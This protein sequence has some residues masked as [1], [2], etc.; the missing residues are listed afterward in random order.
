MENPLV[1][2]SPI[3]SVDLGLN[4]IDD[5]SQPGF[6]LSD[7]S[8]LKSA[9]SGSENSLDKAFN[10]SNGDTEKAL[11][12]VTF[13]IQ[14]L[15]DTEFTYINAL[16]DVVDGYIC[17]LRADPTSGFDETT[18]LEAFINIEEILS[19]HRV[20]HSELLASDSNPHRVAELFLSNIPT[21]TRLYVEFCAAFPASLSRL[22]QLHNSE[23]SKSALAQCQ[24]ELG[25]IFPVEEYLHRA[26]QRF[27][28]YPLLFK[29]MNKKLSPIVGY[30]IVKEALDQLLITALKINSV[31]RVQELEAVELI[32]WKGEKLTNMGDLLLE[33]SFKISGAK[34]PRYLFLFKKCLLVTK[35]KENSDTTCSFAYKSFFSLD[36]ITLKEHV[37]SDFLKWIIIASKGTELT[38]MSRDTEQKERWTREVKRCIV[39]S[40]PGLNDQQREEL[41]NKLPSLQFNV[42]NLNSIWS[43]AHN[44]KRKK[45]VKRSESVKI[46]HS[47]EFSDS[48]NLSINSEVSQMFEVDGPGYETRTAEPSLTTR[49]KSDA[50]RRGALR[51][52]GLESDSGIDTPTPEEAVKKVVTESIKQDEEVMVDEERE[53]QSNAATTIENDSSDSVSDDRASL[54]TESLDL[55]TEKT[56]E[57]L[58]APDQIRESMERLTPLDSVAKEEWSH[59]ISEEDESEDVSQEQPSE[60]ECITFHSELSR[61]TEENLSDIEN[62][63]SEEVEEEVELSTGTES[64][65]GWAS[66]QFVNSEWYPAPVLCLVY[67]LAVA[68]QFVFQCIPLWVLVVVCVGSV[69]G[70]VGKKVFEKRRQ[71]ESSK[72]FE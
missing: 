44:K 12:H 31:K 32:G 25:H 70:L 54:E 45:P 43:K 40:T 57:D 3:P 2:H 1:S 37:Q 28:K 5:S 62:P 52:K 14:E 36:N 10:N 63:K 30:D 58:V 50:V 34:E 11:R 48:D 67:F 41:L 19:F 55:E 20:I 49:R 71:I 42:D 35:R 46:V 65:L 56:E 22:D 26:V 8:S 61:V 15:T 69:G 16:T 53:R 13:L 39:F 6:T 21:L 27:L 9:S 33:D 47:G 18:M 4:S 24:R 51:K 64:L 59:D 60:P 29:D 23:P 38:I 66:R 72:K 68:I 7:I 17:R